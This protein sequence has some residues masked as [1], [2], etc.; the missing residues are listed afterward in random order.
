[1]STGGI[2]EVAIDENGQLICA[3]GNDFKRLT[4]QQYIQAKNSNPELHALTN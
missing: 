4:V 1:M 2:N 3:L